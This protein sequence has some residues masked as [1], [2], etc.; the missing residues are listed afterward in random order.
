MSM[1]RVLQSE[2]KV[3]DAGACA[4][5][6]GLKMNSSLTELY[7]VSVFVF[8]VCCYLLWAASKLRFEEPN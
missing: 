7:L 6:E 8:L 3:G 4:L 5:G 2:N 1:T